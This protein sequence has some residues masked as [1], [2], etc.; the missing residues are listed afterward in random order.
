MRIR[1]LALAAALLALAPSARAE[2]IRIGV[3]AGPHAEIME[4]AKKVAAADGLELKIVEFSDYIQPN[5]ALDA[6]D[7]D[8]NSYQHQPFLDNQIKDRGYKIVAVAKTLVFPMGIYSK[9]AKTL[10]ELAPGARL[11]IPNDPSN[12]GRALLV[13]QSA[14]LLTLDPKAGATASPVDI[15]DNPKKLRI[16]E[17]DAAQLPRALDDVDAAAI[18][19]NYA[20]N[21][22]LQPTRDAIAIESADSPY[23][24]LIAVRTKDKD[25]PWV[26][27]L[28]KA[29][30]SPE[31]KAFVERRF[32][33]AVV[34]GW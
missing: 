19:T 1:H 18:N 34:V 21:A 10:A 28:V 8:A 29:Y 11:A 16:V 3:T 14:G 22:G 33:N 23:T 7:L 5:A 9:K 2:T 30:R 25:A 12:G 24:N 20:L 6:G 17:L 27:K 13:L 4:V 26:A 31:V 15:R 32:D